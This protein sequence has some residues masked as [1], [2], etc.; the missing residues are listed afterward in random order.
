[1]WPR[2]PV[3]RRPECRVRLP[4]QI[5][6]FNVKIELQR[7]DQIDDRD[8][9][10]LLQQGGTLGDECATIFRAVFIRRADDFDCGDQDPTAALVVNL[11][12]VVVLVAKVGFQC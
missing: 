12:F 1:M 5:Q 8:R 9:D 2:R 7:R 4:D 11:H 10:A 6:Q 3:G